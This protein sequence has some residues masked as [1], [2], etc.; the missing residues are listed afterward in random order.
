MSSYV[1]ISKGAAGLVPP[2][3]L[4]LWRWIF[5]FLILLPFVFNG[6]KKNQKY[7]KAE[8]KKLLFL[9]FTGFC[10]CGIFPAISGTT[11]TVINMGII[12]SASPIFIILF[13]FFLFNERINKYGVI[14]TIICL[15]G[16]MVVLSKGK[17]INLVSLKFTPGD[18]W[19][20][21]AMISWAV[22]SIYLMNFKSNFDLVTRFALMTFFGILCMI[23][24]SIV[25]NFYFSPVSFDFN[26]FKYTLMAAILPGI[27]AFLMYAKLQTLVGASMTGLTVYL[28]P[29]YASFYGYL[30]FDEKLLFYHW[31]GG[32]LVIFGIIVA[33]KKSFKPL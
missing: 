17:L 20:A 12:Y 6:I 19:I 15:A 3:S 24:L 26:F 23:P 2:V 21:G 29:V 1:A 11:T 18:L 27:I 5:A 22:Y 25:E 7:I 9:G 32:L 13:S 10:I 31:I 33:N 14:A 30:F 4:A 28:I 16:V 8:W